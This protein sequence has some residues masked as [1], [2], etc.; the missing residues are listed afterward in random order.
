MRQWPSISFCFFS[1]H[2]WSLAASG[3][4]IFSPPF[5]SCGTRVFPPFHVTSSSRA[6]LAPVHD[7]KH[8]RPCSLLKLS[9]WSCTVPS[10]LC[11]SAWKLVSGCLFFLE[12]FCRRGTC[13]IWQ[14]LPIHLPLWQ[15]GIWHLVCFSLHLQSP[16]TFFASPQ[17]RSVTCSSLCGSYR[18]IYRNQLHRT[19]VRYQTCWRV[20]RRLF[21]SKLGNLLLGKCNFQVLWVLLRLNHHLHRW[22]SRLAIRSN[23]LPDSYISFYIFWPGQLLTRLSVVHWTF[24]WIPHLIYFWSFYDFHRF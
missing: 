12:L 21:G 5:W 4:F 24:S 16:S 7:T 13:C 19:F 9:S 14:L 2:P 17:V 11:T 1:F 18:W 3:L 10:D 6:I 22:T 8:L 20:D 23:W 15:I